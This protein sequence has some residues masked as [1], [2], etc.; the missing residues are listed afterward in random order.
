MDK[1][2]KHIAAH[3]RAARL[4]KRL[5][6]EEVAARLGMAT[7][8]ISHIERAVTV[9]SLKTITA[10]ADVVGADLAEMFTGLTSPTALTARRAEREAKLRHL[11]KVLDDRKLESVDTDELRRLKRMGFSDRR[12]AK[13]LGT[14]DPERMNAVLALA[15][16]IY[17]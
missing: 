16:E 1:I 3:L 9:P 2:T 4:A 5:T 10:M 15:K 14:T 17:K 8:S 12:L 7:E 11:T 6:Q 13:L